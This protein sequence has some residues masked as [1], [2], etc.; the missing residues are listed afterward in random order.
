[1][2]ASEAHSLGSGVNRRPV[3]PLFALLRENADQ[4]VFLRHAAVL[5]LSRIG[6]LEAVAAK[7]GRPDRATRH[8]GV[9]V[10]ARSGAVEAVA[11]K[12]VRPDRATRMAVLL[13]LRRAADLRVA[14]F[15]ADPD[16]LLVVEAARAIHDVPIPAA[17]PMLAAL[18]P[19]P[20]DEDP[21]TSYALHR[22]VIDANLRLR[23]QA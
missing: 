20:K 9:L 7:A 5:A 18:S 2:R 22:R 4:D 3:E 10:F 6:D 15:L 19:L 13:C 11:A 8:A 16:P 12:A 14:S 21:E 17:Y 1:L 23:T